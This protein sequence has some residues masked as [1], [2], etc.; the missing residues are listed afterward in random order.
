MTSAGA[1]VYIN[2]SPAP[3]PLPQRKGLRRV[4]LESRAMK[5]DVKQGDVT[6][7]ARYE[8]PAFALLRP[9][10]QTLIE[11]L[12]TQLAPYGASPDSV[13][14][15]T[16]G[17]L[18]N[19][20][21]TINAPG[22][23]GGLKLFVS[24][25]EVGFNDMMRVA[26]ADVQNVARILFESIEKVAPGVRYAGFNVSLN[27]HGF[28]EGKNVAEFVRQYV[29]NVPDLGPVYGAAAAFYYRNKGPR[30]FLTVVMDR[31]ASIPEA[32]YIR[33]AAGFD[34]KQVSHSQLPIVGGGMLGEVLERFNLEHALD[35]GQSK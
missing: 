24:K 10:S 17:S 28:V 19:R 32:L 33:I 12:L 3:R 8:T 27:Y 23:N 25:A 5:F 31:S 29:T 11:L 21:V 2:V 30:D 15:N 20:N 1:R 13:F 6:V 34:G 26:F 22:I 7:E 16:E 35:I 9:E 4:K 18:G 14:Y